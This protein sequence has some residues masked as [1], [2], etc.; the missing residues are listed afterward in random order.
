LTQKTRRRAGGG[1]LGYFFAA[2]AR[3]YL[4]AWR[5]LLLQYRARASD[6]V[7]PRPQWAQV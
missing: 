7:N 4:A 6:A 5:H 3:W 2:F 1:K